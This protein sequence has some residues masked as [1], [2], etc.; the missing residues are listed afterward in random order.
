MKQDK[1]WTDAMRS[2]LRDAEP[3]PPAGGWERLEGELG[4]V[5]SHTPA[6]RIYWLRI[7]AA[8]AV[9]LFVVAGEVLL[10]GD[11]GVITDGNVIGPL[12]D[13]GG[14]AADN[15]LKLKIE[16]TALVDARGEGARAEEPNLSVGVAEQSVVRVGNEAVARSV[17]NEGDGQP[18]P[19]V[20]NGA[21]AGLLPGDTVLIAEAA[22]AEDEFVATAVVGSARVGSEPPSQTASA[23]APETTSPTSAATSVVLQNPE[24]R[25]ESSSE[26]RTVPGSNLRE[27]YGEDIFAEVTPRR[28]KTSLGLFAGG[29]MVGG[30]EGGPS[31]QMFSD[32]MNS[33]PGQVVI[34]QKYTYSDYTFRHALP[35][36]FGLAVRK[37]FP[38]GLSLESGVN[39][40]LLMSEANG[41]YGAKDISQKLHFIGVPL[42]FNWRFFERNRFSL[43]IGA[44]GMVEKCISAK[45]GSRSLDEPKVQWSAL[46]AA[47]AQYRL[48]GVVGLYFEPEASYYFT[49]TSLRTVRTDSAVAFTLR[50]GL[51][52][53]F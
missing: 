22:A 5:K 35:I 13:G 23:L 28:N 31:H 37:D 24:R 27:A 29:G 8:A 30:S 38:H 9:L 21:E 17:A 6:W 25:A 10:R 47:G 39:Y 7:A 15:P 45:F 4:A 50:L 42:R 53:S 51:R 36:S 34:S 11:L 19:S 52:L 18:A 44:G 46:A 32:A 12:A 1:D 41:L 3:T 48:G 43:Y 33:N 14:S 26:A 49:Q 16:A 20:D 40:T 2:S